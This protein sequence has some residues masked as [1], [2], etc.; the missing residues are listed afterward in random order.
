M[1]E[2]SEIVLAAKG[3]TKRFGGIKALDEAHLEVPAGQVTAVMGENGAGKS[4]L[5]KV[6]AGIY[7]DYE[8]RIF[9]NGRQVAFAN[10]RQ[11]QEHGVAIIHQELNL[12]PNLSVAENI[13]LGRE[14]VDRVGLIDFR[15]MRREAADLLHRL[16]LHVDPRTSV[17]EL[18]V[19]QQ[20]VVEIARALALNARVII[21]DEPTWGI[22]VNAKNQIYRL[23]SME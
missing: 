21:M 6:L 11:A 3:I 1:S 22:D 17:S 15:G 4:T 14:S 2:Y 19:G 5:M 12:I 13:F 10:P 18:C 20:Q 8:G 9:L 7:Q 23:I 16:D